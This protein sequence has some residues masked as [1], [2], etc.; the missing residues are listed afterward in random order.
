MSQYARCSRL[1]T[2]GMRW[3]RAT[4]NDDM[5]DGVSGWQDIA[6]RINGD[7]GKRPQLSSHV[8]NGGNDENGST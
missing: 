6:E 4:W 5:N 3:V 2:P 8:F 7:A 1:M